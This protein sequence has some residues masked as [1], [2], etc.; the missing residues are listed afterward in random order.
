M[1]VP[2]F[3]KLGTKATT[4]A[5]LD[6]R[7][8]EVMPS[9]HSL[10]KQAYLAYLSN[11][12][13]NLAIAKNRGDVSGGGKKPWR[14]KGTGRARFGSTRNPIWRGGGA[15]FGPTGFENYTKALN[16][17]AKRM[18]LRQALS[19]SINENKIKVIETLDCKDG[20]VSKIVNLLK[21]IDANG[22]V[23][24]VN[25]KKDALTDRATGNI[26][27]VKIVQANYLNVYDILNADVIVFSQKALDL[28]TAWLID[29]P[30]EVNHE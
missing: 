9:N 4:P 8:F 20:K 21:K 29:V 6:Q 11:G 3:T 24:L 28:V 14:Q 15:A 22:Q 13:Q 7:V 10:L 26:A 23:L 17:H 25:S 2:T 18:A 30:K 5:K 27:N 16:K 19:L 12:R 1:S